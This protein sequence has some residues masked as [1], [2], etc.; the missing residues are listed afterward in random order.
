MQDEIDMH[1]AAA[2]KHIHFFLNMVIGSSLVG[3]ASNGQQQPLMS[4]TQAQT[5]CAQLLLS[6][7]CTLFVCILTGSSPAGDI[8]PA[9][10]PHVPGLVMT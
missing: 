3:L 4:R 7:I 8:C 2:V 5:D 10:V 6:S 9:V 1:V